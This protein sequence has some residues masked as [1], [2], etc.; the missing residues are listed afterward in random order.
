[1]NEHEYYCFLK[2]FWKVTNDGFIIV[3]PNGVIVDIN[4]TYCEFLGKTREQVL[5]K[6]IGEVISTTSMYDVLSSARDGDDNVY[7][8]PYGENDNASNV[9]T[10]A[11]ANRF[12]FFNEQGELLG[13]AAQMSF[14]ER[15]AAMAYSIAT[16]ELNYYKRAYEESSEEDSGFSKILGNSEAMQKLKEKAM[17]VA[18]KDFPV[19]ITGE[20]GTGKELFAQAIHRESSRRKKPSSVSIVPPFRQSY[21]KVNCL[22]MMRVHLPEPR[23]AARSVS[24]SWQ[25][26]ERFSWMRSETC[27]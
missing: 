3:D 18:R 20:T 23:R 12:C 10:H 4:E 13:A 17:R 26:A 7:L 9:E 6:P 14:K 5:G 11:V 25:T 1:M 21:W 2:E 15:A 27:R 8:Q 19:L 16:E 24:F 22:D